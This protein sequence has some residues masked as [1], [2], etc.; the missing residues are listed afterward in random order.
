MTEPVRV[1]VVGVG[2][3]GLSHA[4][5]YHRLDGFEI[6]GLVARSIARADLPA[7]LADYPRFA[8]YDAALAETRPDAV[9]INTYSDS[10]A[11]FAL[12][13]M[14]AGAHVFVEKP[15]ATTLMD[16][17]RIVAAGEGATG[18]QLR[19]HRKLPRSAAACDGNAAES[20]WLP[21][22]RPRSCRRP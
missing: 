21:R 4:L 1:L 17:D 9:S 3:M 14:D 15:L 2:H 18:F 6:V 12:K 20:R 16:A 10:H 7:E 5:A 11:E 8:D 13:A 22:P 19:C